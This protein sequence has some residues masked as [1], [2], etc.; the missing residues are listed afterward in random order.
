MI[1]AAWNIRRLK[2]VFKQKELKLFLNK[3]K[4]D[5]IGCIETK[6]KEPKSKNIEENST[7]LGSMLQLPKYSERADMATM[8]E[9]P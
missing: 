8:E 4:I 5:L 6:V 3:N 7:W 1:I 9:A 2:K